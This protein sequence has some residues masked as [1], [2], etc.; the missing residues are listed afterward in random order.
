VVIGARQC[1]TTVL[2]WSSGAHE[3]TSRLDLFMWL[4]RGGSADPALA[5]A[6]ANRSRE[7]PERHWTGL[8]RPPG[9]P[10]GTAMPRVDFPTMVS[11]VCSW[12]SNG[13]LTRRAR[14]LDD[15]V[16]RCLAR[17][18]SS[19]PSRCLRRERS[20]QALRSS[21]LACSSSSP[22]TGVTSADG[23]EGALGAHPARDPSHPLFA[24]VSDLGPSHL[25]CSFESLC[26]GCGF[27]ATSVEFKGT[28]TR[29]RDHAASGPDRA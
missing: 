26:E 2:A 3:C 14:L 10:S 6:R 11:H 7:R 4:S 12:P 8:P 20:S 18:R 24:A 27:F 16:C 28:L 19:Q 17:R 1:T 15:P 21:S 5:G 22:R 23:P 29:Q 25:G 9:Q 13:R